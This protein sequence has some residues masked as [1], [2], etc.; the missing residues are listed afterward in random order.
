M[1]R[2]ALS[3][4][5]SVSEESRRPHIWYECLNQQAGL[6]YVIIDVNFM[7]YAPDK[8]RLHI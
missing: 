4:S 8:Q 2:L 5:C 7:L 1:Y 6:T 3:G